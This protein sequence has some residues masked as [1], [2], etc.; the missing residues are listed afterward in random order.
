MKRLP[1]LGAI[2]LQTKRPIQGD[3]I[4][5]SPSR[6]PVP[7]LRRLDMSTQEMANSSRSR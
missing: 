7:G 5:T 3:E 4:S 1:I 6:F 2:L